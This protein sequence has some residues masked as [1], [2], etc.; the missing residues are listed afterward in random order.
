MLLQFSGSTDVC[1]NGIDMN[2][3]KWYHPT[4][5]QQLL[6]QGLG[7]L[8]QMN[9]IGYLQQFARNRKFTVLFPCPAMQPTQSTE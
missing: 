3:I 7:V 9:M 2:G 1:H 6:G 4:S 8:N 5:S